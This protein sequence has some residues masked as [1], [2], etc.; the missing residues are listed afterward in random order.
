VSCIRYVRYS[1]QP[2]LN[3]LLR[4]EFTASMQ[5]RI[6]VHPPRRPK[7]AIRNLS[8]SSC[9]LQEIGGD[10]IVVSLVGRWFPYVPSSLPSPFFSSLFPSSSSLL[11]LTLISPYS[12]YS[13]HPVTLILTF[14]PLISN[15]LSVLT[16]PLFC[17][18]IAQRGSRTKLDA[19]LAKWRE[20]LEGI[21][22]RI[23]RLSEGGVWGGGLIVGAGWCIEGRR[24][25]RES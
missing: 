22:A 23:Q 9:M 14:F 6:T 17:P 2:L 4:I 24:R 15:L 16:R 18:R 10:I 8:L 12:I 5:Q 19:D 1:I 21:V 7:H 20:G 25:I 11:P 13:F 3:Y